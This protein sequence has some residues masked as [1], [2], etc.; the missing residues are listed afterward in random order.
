MKRLVI[1]ESP[2]KARTLTKIL[3]P[4]YIIKA[5]VGHIRD[6]P[7]TSFGINITEGFKPTYSILANKKKII[8]ELI[9]SANDV[10]T[11]YLATDPDREGEAISWHLKNAMK[12]D[13]NKIP[14]H[15]VSFHEITPEAVKRAFKNPRSIDMNLVN[16]QQARRLLDRI[17]G[18]K[19]SPF[20][21]K[22]V[23]KGLS[24]GR[25]Q[26]AVVRI[27]VDREKEINAFISKEYWLL[28]VEL[29]HDIQ[30]PSN[31]SFMALFYGLTDGNKIEITDKTSAE[32]YSNILKECKYRVSNLLRKEQKRVPSPPFTTSTLQQE[33]WWK[34]K[35]PAVKTM[36]VAQKLYEGINIGSGSVGLITYMRTDSTYVTPNFLDETREYIKNIYGDIFLPEKTRNFARK[37][38]WSQE[39]H[40]AIRPTKISRTPESVKNNLTKEQ[41]KLY[42]LI[43]RRMIASQMSDAIFENTNVDIMANHKKSNDS[44]LLKASASVM[45]SPGFITIYSASKEENGINDISG[46]LPEL[47]IN[48]NLKFINIYSQQKYTEPA[49]RYNEA[50]LIKVLEKK[51]IG[52]PSTYA[53]I[54]STIQEREYVFKENG[55]F[56]P[57]NIGNIVN[58]IL[59]DYFPNIVD[60]N[61]TA[62]IEDDLDKIAIGEKEWDILLS[63]FYKPFEN[64]LNN[65]T[66]S[67]EKVS[68][69][70][71]EICSECGLPMVIKS[72][73]FGKFLACSGYP[74]CTKTMRIINKVGVACPDCGIEFNGEMVERRNKKKQIFY[75]CSRYPEC[76]FTIRQKPY[77]KQCPKCGS[78]LFSHKKNLLKCVKC[79]YTGHPD[80]LENKA[81]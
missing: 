61:F 52:R 60:L 63:D 42:E 5:S 20:L 47:S 71:D 30:I 46:N 39:A 6:L 51:G 41:Y 45:K 73:R 43:W 69:Q 23:L 58:N 21:W 56:K 19:L 54:I 53:P 31:P 38:K 37:N 28:E 29:K 27:I 35:Y 12:L 10:D 76:R 77:N 80:M 74:D 17:V 33:A 70:S 15:R 59:I 72:G 9:K 11:I 49:P 18:Y 1:V 48:D 22:K 68:I 2:A 4:K 75:G 26:S 55:R 3:G 65:A 40:E 66:A 62:K 57:G 67:M 50:T 36:S 7:K 24:A 44:Y 16:A 81:N 64:S 34:L 14:I 13:E 32:K 79:D 8:R 25:V 78:L